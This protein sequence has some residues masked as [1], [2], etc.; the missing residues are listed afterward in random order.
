MEWI[1]VKSEMNFLWKVKWVKW[2][3]FLKSEITVLNLNKIFWKVKYIFLSEHKF[4]EKWNVFIKEKY[5]L[6]GVKY[7]PVFKNPITVYNES[8]NTVL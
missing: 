7:F 1:F 4:C 6:A 5:I 2:R 3:I 8:L